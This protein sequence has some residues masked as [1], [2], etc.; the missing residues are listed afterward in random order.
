MN[1]RHQVDAALQLAAAYEL[2]AD[3]TGAGLT[4]HAWA[5]VVLK[6]RLEQATDLAN[7]LNALVAQ[8]GGESTWKDKAREVLAKWEQK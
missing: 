8:P 3:A 1:D 4:T 2:Y 5:L 6:D 7:A